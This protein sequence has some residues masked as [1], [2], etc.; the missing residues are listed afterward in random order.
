M[1][2]G[3]SAACIGVG[4]APGG[5]ALNPERTVIRGEIVAAGEIVASHVTRAVAE[6]TQVEGTCLTPVV[7]ESPG[8]RAR[9]HVAAALVVAP[10][11]AAPTVG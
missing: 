10:V 6:R 7:P 3:R 2:A 5:N 11:F 8:E 1:Q 9:L 4:L